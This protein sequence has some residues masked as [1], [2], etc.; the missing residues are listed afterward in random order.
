[1]EHLY[2]AGVFKD[3]PEGL[4]EAIQFRHVKEETMTFD[5]NLLWNQLKCRLLTWISAKFLYLES[6]SQST[7]M[8]NSNS[9]SLFSSSP[10]RQLLTELFILIWS[11]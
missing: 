11:C 4:W 8:T 2:D 5:T 1:M 6:P 10:S 3:L 9:V 7:P